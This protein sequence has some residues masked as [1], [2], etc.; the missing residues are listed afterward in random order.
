MASVAVMAEAAAARVVATWRALWLQRLRWSWQR[1]RAERMGVGVGDA[2]TGNMAA[3]N[4]V[5][6]GACG[7]GRGAR[8]GV[9]CY[10]VA[11]S[12]TL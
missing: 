1:P 7:S 2:V 4:V 8:A 9:R 3:M 12:D 10:G 11:C 5:T 6:G